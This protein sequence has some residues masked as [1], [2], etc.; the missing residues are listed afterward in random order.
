[1]ELTA[2]IIASVMILVGGG[3]VA[4]SDWAVLPKADGGP[5]ERVW[6]VLPAAFLLLL[7]GLSAA[8]VLS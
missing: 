5:W 8:K 1:M 2:L 3:M 7:I 6:V 4:R